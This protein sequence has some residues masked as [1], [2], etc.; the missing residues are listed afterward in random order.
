MRRAGREAVEASARRISRRALVLT[1]QP[2]G[3]RM[4]KVD[5]KRETG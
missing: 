3:N 2:G 1:Y 4:F 5:A